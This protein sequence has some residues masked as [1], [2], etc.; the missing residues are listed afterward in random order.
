MSLHNHKFIQGKPAGFTQNGIGHGDFTDVMKR[1][2][3]NACLTEVIGKLVKIITGL[4]K[5]PN[6]NLNIGRSS[7]DVT[8]CGKITAFYDLCK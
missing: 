6:D 5:S 4:K 8:A 7:L 2:C 3:G 1:S